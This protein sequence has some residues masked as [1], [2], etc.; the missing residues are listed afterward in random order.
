M[1]NERWAYPLLW[2]WNLNLVAAFVGITVFGT[3]RGCEVGELA[4]PNVL[5]LTGVVLAVS[6][7][8]LMTIARRTQQAVALAEPLLEFHRHH[9]RRKVGRVDLLQR[10]GEAIQRGHVR[11]LA[12]GDL[13]LA[14][15]YRRACVGG[16]S[17]LGVHR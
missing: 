17:D 10:L 13:R 15:D 8:L 5:V 3:N 6:L 11:L 1:W 9:P 2:V 14:T 12:V 16:N 4:L 7:Q